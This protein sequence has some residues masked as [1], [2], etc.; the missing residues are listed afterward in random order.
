MALRNG[1]TTSWELLAS[2]IPKTQP[3]PPAATVNT[4]LLG[5]GAKI[6]KGGDVN[7]TKSI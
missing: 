6:K 3:P 7:P 2:P 4:I 5:L 1:A